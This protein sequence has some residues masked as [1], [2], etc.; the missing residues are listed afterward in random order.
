MNIVQSN[1]VDK[2]PL[3]SIIMA[4]EK[5]DISLTVIAFGP[6]CDEIERK[7][8]LLVISNST[9]ADVISILNLE[10][11]LDKGLLVA[12][13]GNRCEITSILSN[14]DEI[15]LLPPVSGG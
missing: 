3:Q 8:N 4:E 2:L 10:R 5:T 14:G 7:Q 12:I 15:A 13:N 9:I 1:C 6:L 11:W